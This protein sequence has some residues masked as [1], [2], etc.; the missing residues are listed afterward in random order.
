MFFSKKKYQHYT[1]E[2]LLP[3][4]S[5]GKQEAFDEL[6]RRYS[7]RLFRFF[8]NQLKNNRSLA[9]DFTQETFIKIFQAA[10]RFDTEKKFSTW[11]FFIAHNIL[12]NHWRNASKRT[13]SDLDDAV[14]IPSNDEYLS[15]LDKDKFYSSLEEALLALKPGHRTCF[16]L[17]YQEDLSMKEISEICQIPEGTVRSRIHY[18]LQWLSVR[19][20]VFD[21]RLTMNDK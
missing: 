19:L 10:E 6:Y 21:F 3:A 18:T 17:R 14:E 8:L 2:L 4:I 9:E 13:T 7:A 5:A 16:I 12:R 20:T 11:A 15:S 1:D